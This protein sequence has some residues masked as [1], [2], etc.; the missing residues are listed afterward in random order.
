MLSQ[1]GYHQLHYK[2]SSSTITETKHVVVLLLYI[3]EGKEKQ[4]THL[5][6]DV[7]RSKKCMTTLFLTYFTTAAIFQSVFLIVVDTNICCTAKLLAC[8][9]C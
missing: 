3:E 6:V 2:Y 1:N 5:Q 8:S 7:L 9:K 4:N